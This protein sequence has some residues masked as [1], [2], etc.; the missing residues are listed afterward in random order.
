MVFKNIG[1]VRLAN[2]NQSWWRSIRIVERIVC[3]NYDQGLGMTPFEAFHDGF[4]GFTKL[5]RRRK[6]QQRI[7]NER[8]KDVGKGCELHKG[9]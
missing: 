5:V 6:Q 9:D 7:L 2:R 1:K 4:Q 8:M 3:R